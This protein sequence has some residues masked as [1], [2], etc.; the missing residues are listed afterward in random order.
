MLRRRRQLR[1]VRLH[2][3]QPAGQAVTRRIEFRSEIAGAVQNP[4]PQAGNLTSAVWHLRLARPATRSPRRTRPTARPGPTF[5]ALT[6]SAV[7]GHPEGRVCSPSAPTRPPRRPA[8]FDYFRLSTRSPTRPRRSTTA[9][10]SGT[11]TDGLVHRAGDGHPRP[12]PTRPAA[13]A[14]PRPST[15]STAPPPGPPTPLRW[16]SAGTATH[17]VRFRSTDKAGNVEATKTVTVKI[18]ATAPVTT[19]TFAPANDAGWHNGDHPGGAGLDRRRFRRQDGG[20]VAGRWRLDAVHHA[21][22][23][24][25]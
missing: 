6:N 20:V 12:R 8:A 10:V 16:R 7:G 11:P 13:A 23:G 1:Q 25:R 5:E 4:Q 21:G 14:S 17:E 24:D 2:R 18:D 3:R 9:T 19:A 22:R 15:S